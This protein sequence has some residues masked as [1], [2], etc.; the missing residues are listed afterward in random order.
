MTRSHEQPVR[1]QTPHGGKH[2]AN[3]HRHQHMQVKAMSN[4]N[5]IAT[6][7]IMATAP[8]G[9]EDLAHT[10]SAHSMLQQSWH[11]MMPAEV[12]RW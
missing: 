1:R 12:A 4:A 3:L 5:A 2:T 8:L 7:C 10:T 9:H 6:C 11:D